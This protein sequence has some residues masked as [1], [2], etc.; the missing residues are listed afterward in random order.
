M[1]DQFDLDTMDLSRQQRAELGSPLDEYSDI[2]SAG[3][4]DLGRTGIVK[5]QIDTGS[6]P[7]I[8]QAPRRVPMHQQETVRQHVEEMLQH[9]VVRPSISP[10]AAPIVLVRK[11]DGTTRFCMDYR[12]LNDV[13]RK[14]AYPLPRIDDTLDALAGAQ[15][16]TTLDL[17]SGYWQVEMDAADRE[18]TAFTT[19]HGLFEFQVMPFGLCNAPGTFQRLMEFV[20]AG[21]QWQTCLVYLDDVIVYGRDFD[22]HLERLKQVFERFR[23]AG[24]KLKPSKCFLLR[25]SVPYL[26]HVISAQGVNTDPDKIEAVRQWPVPSKVTDVL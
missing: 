7:P 9:G 26:G 5:H 16:F 12:K 18:K 3:P 1:S 24:L 10:W 2:F 15:V 22:E 17:A 14:D 25:P 11:K 8:K 21:L 19:R 6:Q 13:T 4:D 20:L 23:Q